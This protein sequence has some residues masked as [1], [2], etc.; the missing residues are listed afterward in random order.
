MSRFN[1]MLCGLALVTLGACT[2][3]GTS[4]VGQQTAGQG[5]A[6][7][8]Q[9][10]VTFGSA[11]TKIEASGHRAEVEG[12]QRLV[13]QEITLQPGGH[14]GWHSHGGLALVSVSAGALSLYSEHHPCEADTWPAGTGFLDP[15]GGH[16][17][18]GK[19]ETSE[20]TVLHVTYI[21]PEG[22]PV[23]IDAPAPAGAEACH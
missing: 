9:A 1:L 21:I 10:N 5:V 20:T 8:V 4:E 11:E 13:T 16:T 22:A 12:P 15:G 14:T 7:V 23:R 19:N 2:D 6:G 3:D 17:H 18:I